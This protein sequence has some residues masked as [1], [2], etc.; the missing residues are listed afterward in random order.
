SLKRYSTCLSSPLSL[1]PCLPSSS[2]GSP[3]RVFDLSF[4]LYYISFSFVGF[5]YWTDQYIYCPRRAVVKV[6]RIEDSIMFIY[7]DFCILVS[8]YRVFPCHGEMGFVLSD[9]EL[10]F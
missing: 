2:L 1:D 10:R 4:S 6:L 9:G 7:E 5:A 8:E 3:S